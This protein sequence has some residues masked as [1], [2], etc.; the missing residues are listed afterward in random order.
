MPCP[1]SCIPSG[2]QAF[3]SQ[4]LYWPPAFSMVIFPSP[5]PNPLSFT[6][7]RSQEYRPLI[8]P[9]HTQVS[10]FSALTLRK[11]CLPRP[12]FFYQLDISGVPG[13]PL[14]HP[15]FISAAGLPRTLFSPFRLSFLKC[16]QHLISF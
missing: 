11:T 10:S 13:K 6:S 8:L 12:Q 16:F 9:S 4:L 1:Q 2:I 14:L 5:P 7:T 3:R 15:Y